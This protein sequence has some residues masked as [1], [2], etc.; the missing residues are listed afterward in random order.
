MKINLN[1][2]VDLCEMAKISAI[3]D[4]TKGAKNIEFT[5]SQEAI[6][7]FATELLRLYD[8]IGNRKLNL[9]THPLQVD[10]APNQVVGFYL[11]PDSPMFMLKINSLLDSKFDFLGNTYKN[12]YIKNININE[13]Y[14]VKSDFEDDIELIYLESYELSKRN[15]LKINLFDECGKNVTQN[16]NTVIFELNSNAIKEFATMLLVWA[17]NSFGEYNLYQ[18]VKDE[19]GYNM[20]IALT[21][22]SIAAKFRCRDLGTVYDFV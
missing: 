13:Y 6:I 8:Y 18:L 12:I 9:C 22:D 15:L 1:K 3:G 21:E 16:Y 14:Y 11:T 10:P 19:C 5:F 2:S 17:N 4:E 20:G 7:G